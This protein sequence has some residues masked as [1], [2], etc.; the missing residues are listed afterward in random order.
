MYT[1][2]FVT[3][4]N[5]R[6]QGLYKLAIILF[7]YI[8]FIFLVVVGSDVANPRSHLLKTTVKIELLKLWKVLRIT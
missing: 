3:N 1:K 6:L 2:S 4:L 8:Y 5:S 7:I